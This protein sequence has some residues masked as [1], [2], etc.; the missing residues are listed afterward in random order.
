MSNRFSWTVVLEVELSQQILRYR[1]DEAPPEWESVADGVRMVVAAVAEQVRYPVTVVLRVV[2]ALAMSAERAGLPRDPAVWLDR[3]TITRYLLSSGLMPSS[4][5]KYASVLA[6]VHEALVWVERGE[7]PRPR[8]R[9][10]R[11]RTA[12]YSVSELTKLDVWAR[13]LPS[14]TTGSQSALAVLLLGAGCGLTP[15]EVVAARGTDILALP[16]GAV[17][18][19]VPNS[20]R[21][22]I[23]RSLWEEQLAELASIAGDDHLFVPERQVAAAKNLLGNWTRRNESADPR[24]PRLDVRRLRSGWIVGLLRDRVPANLVAAA[25]G[26]KSVAALAPYYK[27]VPAPD[28][29]AA[30]RMLR[31]WA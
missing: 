7:E 27:W 25:A 12:P 21:L 15:A 30:V 26:L 24:V 9:A 5:Q 22:V 20:P 28:K 18:V 2:A 13:T 10:D 23:C 6:R 19:A 1:P 29:D 17:A 11:S 4:I 14:T 8:L 3:S 16:S 31:G